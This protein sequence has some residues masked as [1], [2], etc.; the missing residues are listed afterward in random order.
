MA[1]Q[2]IQ[3]PR[4]LLDG[5]IAAIQA[6]TFVQHG[7]FILQLLGS[8]DG[9]NAICG[10]VQDDRLALT[11][12]DRLT[13]VLLITSESQPDTNYQPLALPDDLVSEQID[14]LADALAA[15]DGVNGHD[16][17]A[18]AEFLD[19]AKREPNRCP[20]PH[21]RRRPAN[22]DEARLCRL[23]EEIEA[24]H[25]TRLQ[26]FDKGLAAFRAQA[27]RSGLT[28][29]LRAHVTESD[30]DSGAHDE[31]KRALAASVALNMSLLNSAQHE[32]GTQH[33]V[34][35][36]NLRSL[37]RHAAI[38]EAWRYDGC[39]WREGEPE[40]DAGLSAALPAAHVDRA[41]DAFCAAFDRRLL[42]RCHATVRA[43]LGA[44][45]FFKI[46]P[47]PRLNDRVAELVFAALIDEVTAAPLP[48]MPAICRR[49]DEFA[50][51][52]AAADGETAEFADVA[53][54]AVEDALA[55]GNEW[56]AALERER[57][58]A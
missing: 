47:F 37:F 2:V 50:K 46:R 48:I 1:N 31:R 40:A 35:P 55:I 17:M 14:L 10:A 15:V 52:L 30:V 11:D 45:E 58:A 13:F 44:T 57:P 33:C 20:L 5:L 28:S 26:A 18:F 21:R 49:R 23:A 22:D 38:D 34:H 32:F 6:S 27:L 43:A 29:S 39:L 8:K 54:R 53:L 4:P 9:F 3:C 51:A 24:R 12:D 19:A 36:Q 41:M 56:L 25:A 16:W 7:R 42:A